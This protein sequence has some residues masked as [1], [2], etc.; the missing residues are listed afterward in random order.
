MLF[1]RF[2]LGSAAL[3]LLI[4]RVQVN[5]GTVGKFAVRPRSN[6]L[7]QRLRLVILVLLHGAQSTFIGLKQLRKLRIAHESVLNGRFL[8]HLENFS[9]LNH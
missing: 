7:Q 5:R 1:R 9:W 6:F 3:H 8:G 4:A 2:E